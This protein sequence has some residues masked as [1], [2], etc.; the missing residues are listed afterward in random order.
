MRFHNW[1][2][3]YWDAK[4][5]DCFILYLKYKDMTR[6]WDILAHEPGEMVF[7][8]ASVN[9]PH[10]SFLTIYQKVWRI[11]PLWQ[12]TLPLPHFADLH[13][14]FILRPLLQEPCLPNLQAGNLDSSIT[15]FQP[16]AKVL[17]ILVH[18]YVQ[19][20]GLPHTFFKT[21]FSVLY[22]VHILRLDNPTKFP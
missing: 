6:Q 4:L 19:K 3:I 18:T 10:L 12:S 21:S 17:P 16:L 15:S 20:F 8:T 7:C 11:Y 5:K 22:L 2:I 9:F 1:H 14:R 13:T